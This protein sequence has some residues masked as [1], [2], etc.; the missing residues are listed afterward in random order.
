M[1][2]QSPV[3][4]FPVALVGFELDG[5]IPKLRMDMGAWRSRVSFDRGDLPLL[6]ALLTVLALV[7]LGGRRSARRI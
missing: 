7:F 2:V 5:P 6:A 1:Q 3:G 4:E